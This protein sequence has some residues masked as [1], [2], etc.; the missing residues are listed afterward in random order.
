L[1]EI[2]YVPNESC[3]IDYNVFKGQIDPSAYE[4]IRLLK[5]DTLEFSAF[6][7]L[8]ALSQLTDNKTS[9]GKHFHGQLKYSR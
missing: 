5:K 3:I 4:S 2:P 8:D 9:L 1:I 7:D 6:D